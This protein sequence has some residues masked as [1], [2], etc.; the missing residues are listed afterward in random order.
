MATWI[1]AR[2][3]QFAYFN[4]QLGHPD[5][6][7]KR[8]LDFGGNVGNILLDRKCAI[9]PR[10]YWSI[11][12]SRD[13]MAE[14][15][16]RH[17]EAH[18]LFYDRYN[19]EYNPTGKVGLPI[20]DPGVRFDFIVAWSVVTH[21]S[22]SETL[23]FVDQLMELLTEDGRLAFTFMDPLWTAP[24]GW[25]RETEAPGKSNLGWLLGKRQHENKPEMDV[26]GLLTKV[27]NSK[28]TWLNLVNADK[29]IFDPDDDGLS[30]V[31][32]AEDGDPAHQP[33]RTYLS[34]CT[35]EYMS[36]LYPNA[37]IRP[38]AEPERHHCAIL[39]ARKGTGR[40]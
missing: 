35:P 11:D 6:T 20:P 29:L 9:E 26:P 19:H 13:A 15:K 1:S 30:G 34:F 39:S 4:Q 16:R 7:G 18:F 28:V 36:R 8:V 25:A 32:P 2:M 31:E 37:E 21:N 14:G 22:K 5:W 27:E 33:H 10:D 40:I 23:D 24:P 38:P 3:G 12:V 17:P